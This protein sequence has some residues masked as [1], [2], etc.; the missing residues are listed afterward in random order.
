M[1]GKPIGAYSDILARCEITRVLLISGSSVAGKPIGAYSDI[2]A[3]CEIT[4]VLLLMLLQVFL[5]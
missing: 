1:A 5:F 3:R 4:R 2:L